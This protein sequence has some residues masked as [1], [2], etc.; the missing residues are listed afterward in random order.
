MEK[1]GIA[2]LEATLG[3]QII[4]AKHEILGRTVASEC[5]VM[6]KNSHKHLQQL[7]SILEQVT[8]LRTLR[9]QNMDAFKHILDKVVADRK[10]YDATISTF[11]QANDK[12][13]H[14][15]KNYCVI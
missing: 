14:L 2:T 1:S 13:T 9:G 3:N 15:G 12:I 10:R 4:Q 6:I 5:S 11:N 7:T 8:E